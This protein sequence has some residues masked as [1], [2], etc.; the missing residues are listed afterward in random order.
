MSMEQINMIGDTC[1][2]RSIDYGLIDRI[3]EQYELEAKK[4]E[5]KGRLG[6]KRK[7]KAEVKK[8][9]KP[10]AEPTPTDSI[11][12]IKTPDELREI[13]GA[14]SLKKGI[15]EIYFEIIV[16]Y[17]N[18]LILQPGVKL[19]FAN[20]AGIT[21]KGR[22]EAI[23]K[24]GLEILLT[25]K[26][27]EMGWKNLYLKGRAEA[28]IDY[29]KFS[30]GKGRENPNYTTSGG[31]VLIEG[32]ESLNPSIT[33]N[34]SYFENNSTT[35]GGA[36]YNCKGN[37]AIGEKNMFKN[38]YSKDVGGAI[39]N[40]QGYITIGKKNEFENN[41]A[42]RG[43]AICNDIGNITIKENNIFKKNSAKSEGGGIFSQM[44]R[45]TIAKANIF[46]NNFAKKDGGAIGTYGGRLDID[47]SKNTFIGNKPDDIS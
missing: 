33:I 38:N 11:N 13:N 37:V 43:G 41:S 24:D 8:E 1:K 6:G 4:R 40:L 12:Y 26:D 16:P 3:N 44:G 42:L 19:Y 10:A 39:Y 5:I 29:A 27:E 46:E 22:F 15:Y 30:S 31:A 25:A 17:G 32:K 35:Y 36:I 21:C 20:N 23:G 9:E 47:E 14:Y 28:I 45:M 34:N 7:G 2:D 18:A